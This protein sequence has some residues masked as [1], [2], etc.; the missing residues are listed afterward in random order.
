MSL[1]FRFN[2]YLE[3]IDFLLPNHFRRK[4]DQKQQKTHPIFFQEKGGWFF[5]ITR[6]ESIN[7]TFVPLIPLL[8]KAAKRYLQTIMKSRLLIFILFI[9]SCSNSKPE[10]FNIDKSKV[11]YL[12]IRKRLDTVSLCLS[13]KQFNNIF[14]MFESTF[15]RKPCKFLEQYYLTIHFKNDNV[16]SYSLRDDLIKGP[17]GYTYSIGDKEYFKK[18]WFELSGLTDRHIEYYPTY[19]QD[20]KLYQAIESLDKEH[21]EGIKKVLTFYNHKWKEA[22]GYVFYEGN[23]SEEKLYEYTSKANDRIWLDSLK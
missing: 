2:I 4:S 18:I 22:G 20:G 11:N 23:I 3:T 1:S 15:E 13:E 9:C 21:L 10:R 12:E 6:Y 16:I 5:S 7:C 19:K 8:R 17:G 14:I